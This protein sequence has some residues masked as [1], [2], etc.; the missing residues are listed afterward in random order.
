MSL[1][2]LGYIRSH[3]SAVIPESSLEIKN[4]L[5]LNSQKI[6][7]LAT[8]TAAGDAANKAYVD[9]KIPRFASLQVTETKIDGSAGGGLGG[10]QVPITAVDPILTP[11]IEL[12]GNILTFRASGTVLLTG[13]FRVLNSAD[14]VLS[15]NISLYFAGALLGTY[16]VGQAERG[17]IM[18]SRVLTVNQGDSGAF[19]V[20]WGTNLPE[21]QSCTMEET[22]IA[23]RLYR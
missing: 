1:N 21:G 14:D 20:N 11:D 17:T 23:V 6:A 15:R 8:P 2:A 10:S 9:S 12:N 4:S 13:S 7:N 18:I 3:S 22:Q 5:D 19:G 16:T